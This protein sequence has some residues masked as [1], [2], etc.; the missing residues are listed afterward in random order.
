MLK[1]IEK[2]EQGRTG[3]HQDIFLRETHQFINIGQIF[4]KMSDNLAS[5]LE[6]TINR[7]PQK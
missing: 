1:P 2:P 4:K 6:G 7:A 3:A 5:T